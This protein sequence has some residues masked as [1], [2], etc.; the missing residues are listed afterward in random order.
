MYQ[1]S[2][3]RKALVVFLLTAWFF[4]SRHLVLST[5]V[6]SMY[7]ALGTVLL[8]GAA[9]TALLALVCGF[10]VAL[11]AS[12]EPVADWFRGY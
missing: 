5:E 1:R 11:V 9:G 10:L 8:V 6:S 4:V 2:C 7:S 3:N 12:V